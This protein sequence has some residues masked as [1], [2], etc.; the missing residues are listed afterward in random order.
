M[1]PEVTWFRE[2]VGS[3]GPYQI[4]YRNHIN[5]TVEA[6][7]YYALSDEEYTKIY[8]KMTEVKKI[9]NLT[10]KSKIYIPSKSNLSVERWKA[11]LKRQNLVRTYNISD[12]DI[13]AINSL[14]YHKERN[15]NFTKFEPH[16]NMGFDY[17]NLCEVSKLWIK[18]F[19]EEYTCS[20]SVGHPFVL[21]HQYFKEHG[22]RFNKNASVQ[23]DY[24]VC[25][26]RNFISEEAVNTYYKLMNHN[27][28]VIDENL[29]APLA[30]SGLV[31][32]DQNYESIKDMLKSSDEGNHIV[33]RKLLYECDINNSLYYIW[34][35][36]KADNCFWPMHENRTKLGREFVSTCNL[37]TLKNCNTIHFIK[38]M[39]NR[40]KLT[41]DIF[42]RVIDELIKELKNKLKGSLTHEFL[43]IS[44]VFNEK[45]KKYLKEDDLIIISYPDKKDESE[46]DE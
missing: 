26:K 43:D 39:E 45:Y 34:R 30:G 22:I 37:Y 19:N 7:T 1:T 16:I 9:P 24:V 36:A 38:Y 18:A 15:Y 40:N 4:L 13:I 2:Q 27:T 28:L 12:A 44:C 21:S 3:D 10:A 23:S 42:Y 5:S 35:L 32:D 17:R 20:L 46:E 11:F 31:L 25:E 6:T 14:Q 8:N 29:L 33:A 41:S